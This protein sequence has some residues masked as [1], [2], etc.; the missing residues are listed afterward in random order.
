MPCGSIECRSDLPSS[1]PY[2]K[3]LETGRG[4]FNRRVLAYRRDSADRRYKK[5][6]AGI[7]NSE[8]LAALVGDR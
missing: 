4:E 1:V 6:G 5:G 2:I 7:I 3:V 8:H